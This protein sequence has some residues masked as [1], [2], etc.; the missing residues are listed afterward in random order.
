[1]KRL[2]GKQRRNRVREQQPGRPLGGRSVEGRGGRRASAEQ[3]CPSEGARDRL[4][5]WKFPPTRRP[6]P[7]RQARRRRTR[8]ARPRSAP[9]PQ[10]PRA[11]TG[12]RK[13]GLARRS[14][15]STRRRLLLLQGNA[16]GSRAAPAGSSPTLRCTGGLCVCFSTRA[17]VSVVCA[18]GCVCGGV[19][20][21]GGL[22]HLRSSLS[23]HDGGAARRGAGWPGLG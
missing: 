21:V 9:R 1:M 6:A 18:C 23:A 11:A 4:S 14:P 8:P 20:G 7:A 5:A 2:T 19:M 22:L 15:H 13:A 3:S 10:M 12:Q 16:P 17:R